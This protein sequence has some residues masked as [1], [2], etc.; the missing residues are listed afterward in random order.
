M[1]RRLYRIGIL[2]VR[3]D[4]HAL[5]VRHELLRYRDVE[6]EL[7]ETDC[8]ADDGGLTWCGDS[9]CLVPA[10]STRQGRRID[11]RLLDAIWLRRINFPQQACRAVRDRASK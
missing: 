8:I 6:C 7:I 4:L 5:L 2:S 11:V 3:N 10:L 1:K 9:D